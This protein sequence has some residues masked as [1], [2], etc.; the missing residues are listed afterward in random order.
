M[1]SLDCPLYL[2]VRFRSPPFYSTPINFP[3]KTF[4]PFRDQSYC[5]H[6][7]YS[8]PKLPE[9]SL[10]NPGLRC[11]QVGRNRKVFPAPYPGLRHGG[12]DN[13][14]SASRFSG[15]ALQGCFRN[16]VARS[17]WLCDAEYRS[18]Q[19]L[20][21]DC[22]HPKNPLQGCSSNTLISKSTFYM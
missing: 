17:L 18:F 8:V 20:V 6:S 4:R 2:A 19:T 12:Q 10:S 11:M 3:I 16:P 9:S 5:S 22:G 15:Q 21:S 1:Q 7:N 13:Q 14:C